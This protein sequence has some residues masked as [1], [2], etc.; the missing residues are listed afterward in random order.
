MIMAFILAPMIENAL[1]QSLLM[2][3]G[4]MAI[5]VQRPISVFFIGLFA[6]IVATQVVASVIAK[7]KKAQTAN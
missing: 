2:S 6:L 5:F 4:S 3:N 1:R 7:K